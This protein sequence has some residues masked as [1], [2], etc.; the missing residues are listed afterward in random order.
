MAEPVPNGQRRRFCPQPGCTWESFNMNPSSIN[1]AS[2]QTEF[3]PCLAVILS[4]KIHNV[5]ISAK[6][7]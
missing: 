7:Q 2:W 6:N 1:A 3:F 5:N 4:R